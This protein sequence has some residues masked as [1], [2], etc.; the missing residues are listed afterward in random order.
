MR[1][2]EIIF[3]VFMVIVSVL[4]FLA[5][6]FEIFIFPKVM[7]FLLESSSN[8][9]SFSIKS[10]IFK[11]PPGY[12][13]IGYEAKEDEF[14][15]IEKPA[16]WAEK[17]ERAKETKKS[18]GVFSLT[19][20]CSCEICCGEFAKNRPLDENGKEI[21]YGAIGQRL[22]PSY[23]IAVDPNVIPYGSKV[24]IDG[25]VYC[26]QDCGGGIKGHSIDVY[27]SDHQDALNFG[28]QH[29]EVFLLGES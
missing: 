6:V 2:R 26:A 15:I 1:K 28:V 11:R 5:V 10:E 29:K 19:A 24:E 17:M 8:M 18:L 3:S 7:S 25:S 20:Y 16:G 4:V 9:Q 14:F 13:A 22:I 23:S 21:V 27:F 12:I